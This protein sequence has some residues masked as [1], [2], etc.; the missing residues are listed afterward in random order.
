MRGFAIL[1]AFL[2]AAPVAASAASPIDRKQERFTEI[3]VTLT[4]ASFGGSGKGLGVVLSLWAPISDTTTIAAQHISGIDM[5]GEIY[6]LFSFSYDV[7][8]AGH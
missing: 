1:C 7:C 5:E 2:V 6:N 4:G 8:P 3:G